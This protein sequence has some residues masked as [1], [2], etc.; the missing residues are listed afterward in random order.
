MRISSNT[1]SVLIPVAKIIVSA[2]LF[3]FALRSVEGEDLLDIMHEA[4]VKYLAM[5]LGVF[6]VG[7]MLSSYRYLI[8]V[9]AYGKAISLSY[10]LRIHF[11]GIFFNQLLPSGVGGDVVKGYYVSRILTIRQA[12]ISVVADRVYGV[13]I[14]CVCILMLTP[15]YWCLWGESDVF[16][17]IMSV[18]A[19]GSFWLPISGIVLRGIGAATRRFC[20]SMNRDFGLSMAREFV[21]YFY[22]TLFS[23]DSPLL[24]SVSVVVHLTGV[25]CF[26]L[27][28]VAF[29]GSPELMH[30]MLV[31]P[32]VF[33]LSLA[34]ISIA[35]WGVREVSAVWLL[36]EV[37]VSA[38][39]ALVVSVAFGL[40]LL[41]ASV[42]GVLIFAFWKNEFGY[43]E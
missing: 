10:S 16:W 2:G 43:A 39:D 40:L 9:R 7:Q 8:L 20:K 31:V 25:L 27:I 34:P 19:L 21:Q 38:G 14:L 15:E 23:S 42:P 3:F 28:A 12:A 17:L 41:L 11:V 35:G 26:Y 33:L 13:T 24:L 36:G 30:F 4:K 22:R 29:S 1:R 37:G 5:A 32:L 6:L 18:G